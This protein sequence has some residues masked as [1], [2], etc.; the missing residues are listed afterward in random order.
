MNKMIFGAIALAFAVPGL[1]QTAPAEPKA[2]C[3]EKM[4]A[5]GKECCCKDMAQKN[6]AQDHEMKQDQKP[7]AD[8]DASHDG[9]GDHA[10]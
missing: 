6:H 10:H 1:A 9:H 4:N 7:K 5:E 8:S 3:C 2:N